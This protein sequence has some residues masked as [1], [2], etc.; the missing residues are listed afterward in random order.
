MAALSAE[1]SY[2]PSEYDHLSVDGEIKEL[3]NYIIK[4]TPQTIELEHKFKPFIPEYIPAVG[5]IDAFIRCSRPDNKHEVSLHFLACLMHDKSIVNLHLMIVSL[6]M[7]LKY[8]SSKTLGLTVLDEPSATQS[9]PSV[10]ELQL[11]VVTKQSANKSAKIKRVKANDDTAAVD[12]WIRDISDL[13]RSKP[14]PSVHYQKTMPDI[15]NLMQ[16]RRER[17]ERLV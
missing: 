2:D 17:G 14:P 3:F 7:V 6:L 12:K 4:Y 10:L 1:G 15:D 16:V 11:R 5:D 8:R 13:H 9:D